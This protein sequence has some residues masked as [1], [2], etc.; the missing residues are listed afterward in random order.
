MTE[1]LV[2]GAVTG[3]IMLIG[4]CHGERDRPKEDTYRPV[5]RFLRR[6]ESAHGSVICR[7]LLGCDLETD[8]QTDLFTEVCPPLVR[9]A[10][11]IVEQIIE[12]SS[13][14]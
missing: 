4:L 11:E 3:A 12:P 9:T 2:C 6:F 13:G 7:D 8:R 5:N 14:G 1:G 10:A